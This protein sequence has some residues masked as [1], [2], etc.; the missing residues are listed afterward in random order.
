MSAVSLEK[1]GRLPHTCHIP[2]LGTEPLTYDEASLSKPSD[3]WREAITNEFEGSW[4][5]GF[6][7]LLRKPEGWS[8]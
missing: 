2:E 6:P 3:V 7:L 1:L 5:Q 8:L 4:Q